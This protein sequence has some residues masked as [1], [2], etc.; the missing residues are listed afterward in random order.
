MYVIHDAEKDAYVWNVDQWLPRDYTTDVNK[1]RHYFTK[2]AAD[3]NAKNYNHRSKSA[4]YT[5]RPVVTM[6]QDPL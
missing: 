2:E 3:K 4:R 1:A 6:V 5:V